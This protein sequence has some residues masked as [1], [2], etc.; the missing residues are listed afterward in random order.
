[1]A[2]AFLAAGKERGFIASFDD[3][4]AIRVETGLGECWRKQIRA[5]HAP[6]DLSARAR[7]DA[8]GEENGGRSVQG[9]GSAASN[10]MQRGELETFA[11]KRV[12]DRRNAKWE[13]RRIGARRRSDAGDV[14]SKLAQQRFVSHGGLP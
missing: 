12:V 1:M 3:D 7:R 5:G 9:A 13:R 11:G 14:V 2:K 10:L 6:Q 8:G 4:D